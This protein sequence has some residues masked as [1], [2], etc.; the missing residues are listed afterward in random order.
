MRE[1][2]RITWDFILSHMYTYRSCHFSILIEAVAAAVV[3]NQL[4]VEVTVRRKTLKLW[5]LV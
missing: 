5:R 4:F 1:F 2:N 3:V